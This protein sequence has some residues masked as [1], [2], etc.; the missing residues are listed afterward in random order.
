M[1]Y[2]DV[3]GVLLATAQWQVDDPV[4]VD[5][6]LTATGHKDERHLKPRVPAGRFG[7]I[8]HPPLGQRRT[9]ADGAVTADV[10]LRHFQLLLGCLVLTRS[11]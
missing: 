1:K 6:Q 11:P 10:R 7:F 3:G 5:D 2:L 9:V 8:R 4:E